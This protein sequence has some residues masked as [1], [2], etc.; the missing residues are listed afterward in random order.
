M[1][2]ASSQLAHK[3]SSVLDARLYDVCQ[4]RDNLHMQVGVCIFVYMLHSLFV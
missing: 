3:H 4:E 1:K 2:E